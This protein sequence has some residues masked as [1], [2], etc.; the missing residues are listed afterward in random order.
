M[1]LDGRARFTGFVF[2]GVGVGVVVVVGWGA[3]PAQNACSG[4]ERKGV[5]IQLFAT[6]VPE[7]S[8]QTDILA[9]SKQASNRHHR[10]N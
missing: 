3:G 1:W 10:C 4:M 6:V 5:F 7:R 9:E 8:R 2:V